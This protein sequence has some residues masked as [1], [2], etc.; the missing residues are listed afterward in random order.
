MKIIINSQKQK[1]NHNIVLF[2]D[3]NS[4]YDIQEKDIGIKNYT[5][6][7]DVIKKK[8]HELNKEKI[9]DFQTSSLQ[10]IIIVNLNQNHLN[11]KNE[12]IGANLYEYLKKNLFLI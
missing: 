6:F 9:I 3:T 2:L 1:K 8:T 5:A 11:L 7:K 4:R 10:R 12:K